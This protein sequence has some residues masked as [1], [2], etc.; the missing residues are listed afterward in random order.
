M[1]RV[2][3]KGLTINYLDCPANGLAAVDWR[4]A[5]NVP[6]RPDRWA[7]NI[8]FH[9]FESEV[10]CR[11]FAGKLDDDADLVF[12]DC[13]LSLPVD[14]VGKLDEVKF[15]RLTHPSL[16]DTEAIV[17]LLEAGLGVKR[18]LKEE[19]CSTGEPS[20]AP[21]SLATEA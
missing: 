5:N 14:L 12:R 15:E 19:P 18:L 16:D 4:M 11:M 21:S 13:T 9:E 10:V 6:R 7:N 8:S 2:I 17:L 1:F 3:I 20:S